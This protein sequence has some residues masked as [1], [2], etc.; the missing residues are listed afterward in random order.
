[1]QS[2]TGTTYLGLPL[3]H[4]FI[5]GASPLSQHVDS[6]RALEEAGCAAVVLHSLFEE[7]VS[8]ARSDRIS[9]MDPHDPRFAAT[10]SQYPEA[11]R[12][13]SSPAAY[14]EHVARAKA[15][16]G[17]PVIA[18]LNGGTAES[19]LSI[20]RDIQ[21]AGADALELNLYQVVADP[22]L[23]S[24]IV[25]DEWVRMVTG[26]VRLLRIP[27][28]VKV[29]PFFTAFAHVA[30]RFVDAG[31][32]GLVLFNRVYQPDIDIEHIR[33]A[34][35]M[36]LSTS[37]ELLLRLRWLALLRGRVSCDLAVTGGVATSDD[38]IKGL[39]AG[40]DAVQLVS[41]LLRHG[42]GVVDTMR[43]GLEDW[44]AAHKVE[45]LT[46]LRGRASLAGLDDPLSFERAS[47]LRTLTTW[48]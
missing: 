6:L 23:T 9:H 37:A 41:A 30:H 20:A 15:A 29:T 28:A 8:A 13:P 32:R 14:L 16:L 36:D 45:T 10:L 47:Y 34:V 7:Q 39:L 2:P 1:M 26:L 3:P 18:S 44:M 11:A 27:V 46:E 42:P 19:W 35:H 38:A 43:T 12:A 33:H 21:Q 4:P 25:E 31:A 17:I 40:A 5:A 22:R 48:H 24:A